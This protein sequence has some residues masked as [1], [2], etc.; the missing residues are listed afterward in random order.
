MS[1]LDSAEAKEFARRLRK[2]PGA[3]L[4]AFGAT[5]M[6]GTGNYKRKYEPDF[7]D[8]KI[9]QA[10]PGRLASAPQ[11]ESLGPLAAPEPVHE[12]PASPIRASRNWPDYQRCVLG[13]PMK[14]W[15]NKPDISRADFFFAMLCAQR[16]RRRG[17]RQ[18]PDGTQQQSP[19]KR[20]ALR[21]AD[22][23]ECCGGHG[24]AAQEPGLT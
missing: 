19:G 8:V 9:L 2:G 16:F 7:P 11:F 21:A 15:E 1:G 3:D 18:P 5:R 10:A 14:H 22:S 24:K 12:A 17:N 13:A 6:A 20:G 23:G 4:T